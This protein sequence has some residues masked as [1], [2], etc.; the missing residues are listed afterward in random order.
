MTYGINGWERL[1]IILLFLIVV[2][3]ASWMIWQW[4]KMINRKD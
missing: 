2:A 3:L 1:G 4:L